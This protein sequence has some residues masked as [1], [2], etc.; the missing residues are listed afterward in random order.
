MRILKARKYVVIFQSD[1]AAKGRENLSDLTKPIY[2][3]WIQWKTA[4]CMNILYVKHIAPHTHQLVSAAAAQT[5]T[6]SFSF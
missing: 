4:F 2:W 5:H 3:G 6:H 1:D